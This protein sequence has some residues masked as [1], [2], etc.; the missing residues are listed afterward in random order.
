MLECRNE[1]GEVKGWT[2]IGHDRCYLREG[3]ARTV[4]TCGWWGAKAR[5]DWRGDYAHINARLGEHPWLYT[6]H[7]GYDLLHK[8]IG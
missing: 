1:A 3:V 2:L 4:W 5:G 7:A 6:F 8:A